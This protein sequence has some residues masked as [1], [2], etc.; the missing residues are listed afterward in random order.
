MTRFRILR[1]LSGYLT[2]A[3]DARVVLETRFNRNDVRNMRNPFEPMPRFSCHTVSAR[4]KQ[5]I[6][7][8]NMHISFKH[9]VERQR[10]T[11]I[12]WTRRRELAGWGAGQAGR[13]GRRA[14]GRAVARQRQRMPSR[15][16]DRNKQVSPWCRRGV[17][18]AAAR[19]DR[20]FA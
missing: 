13:R 3:C 5:A 9:V 1:V 14:V 6:Q 8:T 12:A 2:E 11:R 16:R 19:R 15:H 17:L 4:P 20:I 18:K 7:S 10:E